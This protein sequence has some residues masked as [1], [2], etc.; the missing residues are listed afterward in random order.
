MNGQKT[1]R[2]LLDSEAYP[3]KLKVLPNPRPIF[4]RGRQELLNRPS[5]AIVGSRDCSLYGVAVATQ[6]GRKAAELGVVVVSGLAKG[7]DT[8]AHRGALEARGE[9]I[10]VLGNGLDC[11]YPAANQKLQHQIGVDGLLLGEYPDGT[12]PARY[13]F[14]ARN[15]IISALSDAVVVVEAGTRSGALITAEVAMDQ[16][17]P[18][19]AVPGNLTSVSSFGTNKLIAEGAQIVYAVDQMFLEIWG[20]Q[21]AGSREDGLAEEEQQVMEAI[22]AAGGETTVDV[23]CHRINKYPSQVTGIITVLEMKGLVFCEMGKIGVAS[24]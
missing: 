5:L 13:T 1:R 19:Y 18:V 17:R 14:P 23:I 20:R 7:I 11:C 16:G 9:T 4:V 22:R 6:I 3:E 12:P 8:A 2:I 21:P 24:F 15:R 10:A